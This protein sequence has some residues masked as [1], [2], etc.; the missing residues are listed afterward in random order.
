M[1]LS[2]GAVHSSPRNK[3]ALS[4]HQMFDKRHSQLNS[5]L[6]SIK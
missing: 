2:H 3:P 4:M 5:Q 6:N 1:S